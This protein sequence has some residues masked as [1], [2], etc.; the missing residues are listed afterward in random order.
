MR[1]AVS[2]SSVESEEDFE[3]EELPE[4]EDISEDS[5]S[6]DSDVQQES[7]SVGGLLDLAVRV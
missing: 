7:S 6:A 2:S 5:T 3:L 1:K 4:L